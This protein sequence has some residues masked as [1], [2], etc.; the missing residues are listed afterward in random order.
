M[1]LTLRINEGNVIRNL[2]YAF[3]DRYTVITEL[4][5]NA[6]R[7]GSPS[8]SVDYDQSMRRLVVRD[9]GCGIDDFQDL[10]SIA[11]SGWSQT[12]IDSDHPFGLG[13][14]Q[15]LY[16][17]SRATV[18]SRDQYIAFSTADVLSQLPV[19]VVSCP[20]FQGTEVQL[21]GIDLPDLGAR[22]AHMVA[23][24]PIPVIFNGAVIARP[25]A[26]DAMPFQ[27][28]D[29]G[30]VYL[31]GITHGSAT[32]S[33]LI[34]LQ[35]IL[36]S[37]NLL[38]AD[39]NNVIHLDSRRFL[40]RLP[41]RH[42]L[43][44]APVHERAIDDALRT[45][46]RDHLVQQKTALDAAEFVKACFDAAKTWRLL[47]LLDDVPLLP[48][49][50]FDRIS[51]YP[52]QEGDGDRDYLCPFATAVTREQI[53]SGA[54]PLIELD[55]PDEENM[56]IW[57]YARA[58]GLVL[59][60]DPGLSAKHWVH[61][62][63]RSMNDVVVQVFLHDEGVRAEFDGQW[64]SP[65]VVLC[66]AYT[67]EL[68]GDSVEIE[69]DAMYWQQTGLLV[70]PVG[71]NTGHAVR[72]VSNYMGEFDHFEEGY[73][74]ADIDALA[75]LIRLLRATDPCQALVSML[76]HLRVHEYPCLRGRAFTLKVP[77]QPG[78]LSVELVAE[79]A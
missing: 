23:G 55:S 13:F 64:I 46:W 68:A 57:M 65:T 53:E 2:R 20:F 56:P 51:D 49:S 79:A 21:D 30:D 47:D 17:A 71:E 67:L 58:K 15:C 19:T 7:S 31:C 70:V 32:R 22:M 16:A 76:A 45:V 66:R 61:A 34:F 39:W 9:A 8:V 33:S 35:G 3:T 4:L 74:D 72:Q 10:F 42:S 38:Y 52:Y 24:F 28:I 77:T 50:L 25:Y 62:R 44:D 1:E 54:V 37:G 75:H 12:I 40:A 48:A 43:I 63:V 36:V 11:E 18:R 14:M 78:S 73:L 26:L 69:S 59:F 5:Q 29:I 27:H 6:R 60:H 41:D